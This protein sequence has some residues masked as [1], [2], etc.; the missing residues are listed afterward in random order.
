MLPASGRLA[1]GG[2]AA[3]AGGARGGLLLHLDQRGGDGEALPRRGRALGVGLWFRSVEAE[4]G[5]FWYVSGSVALA[6]VTV[7]LMPETRVESHL[8][9]ED[10]AAAA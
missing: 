2:G 3:G 1:A 10:R 7:W 9:R 5:F 6:V 4:S 8:T